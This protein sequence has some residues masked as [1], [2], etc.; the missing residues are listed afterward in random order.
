MAEPRGLSLK[1]W[2]LILEPLSLHLSHTGAYSKCSSEGKDVQEENF[3]SPSNNE[4]PASVKGI[5]RENGW[6]AQLGLY[7]NAIILKCAIHVYHYK[8]AIHS[9]FH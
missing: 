5:G 4:I 1:S 8:E 2:R 7:K 9:E 6:L 3:S